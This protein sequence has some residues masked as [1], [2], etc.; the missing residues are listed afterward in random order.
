MAQRVVVTGLGLVTPVGNDVESTWS[1]LLA[2]RSGAAPITKFDP[3]A[4]QVRFACEI[5]NFDP[6]Q[7]MDRKE[8]KRYDAF[9]QYALAAAHQAVTQAGLEGRFPS[10]DRTGVV[11]GSGI[12]GMRTFEDQCSIYL[13]KGPDRVSPFFVPMFIPDIAAGLVSIRYGTKGPN[14]ATVSACASSAHAI[15][16]SYTMIRDGKADAMICGGAE[17]AI[18]GLAIA[19]FQNMR[20]LSTRNDS[21]ETAS[22]PFDRDRDGFVLGDGAGVVILESLEHA[23]GRGATI[24]GEVVGYGASGD[25]YHMTSPAPAGEGAQRAMRA[26]LSDRGIDPET[27]GYINAHGTSTEQGDVAE[28][29]AVKAVFGDH[30]RDLVFGSTKSMTGHLLGAAGALEFAVSLL[31]VRTGM[32]P[33]TINQFTPDPACDLDCA[34]NHKVERSLDV[35]IS[36]S[37]GFGGHNATIA[38]R[39]WR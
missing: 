19:G 21:P 29:E 7:Y 15:G 13:T 28:T 11:I 22:R 34:P 4:L 5:K 9:V 10:P 36:N 8:A 31:A 17:A 12:G 3:S 18:T 2:G 38:V 32:I 33:P 20:A 25:A 23:Q 16:E 30:A 27:V 1:A 37:F 14:F 35:A 6:S 24:L 26:A 39:G